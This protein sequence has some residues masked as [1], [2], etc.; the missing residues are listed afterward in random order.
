MTMM[1]RSC[2]LLAPL[3]CSLL[4]P[5]SSLAFISTPR[6][7]HGSFSSAD[8]TLLF[9]SSSRPVID[10]AK[11]QT[12]QELVPKKDAYKIVDELVHNS[13]LIDSSEATFQENWKSLETRV[14]KE[15]RSVAQILGSTTTT[16]ILESVSDIQYDKDVVSTFL[17]S[18]AIN[19]L[20]AMILYDGISEFTQRIDI[21]GN[22]VNS[23]PIIGPI[24]KQITLQFKQQLDRSLGP[25]I[26]SFLQAY[27]KVAIQ[28]AIEFVLSEEN[29]K[30][31]SSANQN[32]VK[33]LLNRPINTLLPPS[34]TLD[35]L[36][37]EVFEYLRKDI[38]MTDV[39]RYLDVVYDV[40]EDKSIEDVVDV[41]QV[42]DASPT[43]Q[44]TLDTIWTK[45]K[46]IDD[47]ASTE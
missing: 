11:Q 13:T 39:E 31:F 4:A 24:R 14:K 37:H 19:S 36:Q 22:I 3:L 35:T 18:N 46:S 29:Q 9:A 6:V 7:S 16:R 10:W 21:F 34:D 47:S 33:S 44:T 40:V 43:L 42:L 38:N 45:V 1:G 8:A 28:Q 17:N 12:L 2:A 26:R 23:L 25:L 15:D 5:H 30:L 27:T 41:D 32:L 20:F